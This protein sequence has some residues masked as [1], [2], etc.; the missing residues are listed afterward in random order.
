MVLELS[1]STEPQLLSPLLV[2]ERLEQLT[3]SVLAM[4]L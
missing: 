3:Q 2:E 4:M 1:P